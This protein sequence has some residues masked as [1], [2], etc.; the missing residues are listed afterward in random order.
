[1]QRVPFTMRWVVS[2]LLQ[3]TW[4][5]VWSW[6]GKF[7]AKEAARSKRRTRF[8]TASFDLRKLGIINSC[9]MVLL[10]LIGVIKMFQKDCVILSAKVGLNS[11]RARRGFFTTTIYE[12]I[13][14]YFLLGFCCSMPVLPWLPF[15]YTSR[16]S[17]LRC[18]FP[19]KGMIKNLDTIGAIQKTT[20]SH[21]LNTLEFLRAQLQLWRPNFVQ[22]VKNFW[23]LLD[24]IV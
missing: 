7:K 21:I 23:Y 24:L 12:P 15:T 17:L 9:W 18:F 1:M 8:L 13:R 5:P 2:K 14:H 11:E 6:E 16:L 22:S 19:N 20:L 3:G 10:L 4:A